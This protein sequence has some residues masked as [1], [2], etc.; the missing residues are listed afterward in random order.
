MENEIL[1][2]EYMKDVNEISGRFVAYLDKL[3][4]GITA[5]AIAEGKG[6]RLA[7]K[8]EYE[9]WYRRMSSLDRSQYQHGISGI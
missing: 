4:R 5:D 8:E 2:H 7:E 1:N 9:E 3:N 6:L